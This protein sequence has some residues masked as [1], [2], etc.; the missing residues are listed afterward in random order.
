MKTTKYRVEHTARDG[1]E[2]DGWLWRTAEGIVMKL[3]GTVRPKRGK[4][5]EVKMTLANVKKGPQN[6][7]LFDLPHGLMK[8]PTGALG[9]LLG[10]VAK[11]G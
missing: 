8:L 4:P 3:D 6:A 5:A 11:S 2:V 7:S 1:T 10:G 9:P